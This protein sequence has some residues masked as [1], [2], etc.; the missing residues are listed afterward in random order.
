M[1]ERRDGY[2]QEGRKMQLGGPVLSPAG[3]S[4]VTGRRMLRSLPCGIPQRFVENW[5]NIRGWLLPSSDR[6]QRLRPSPF[7]SVAWVPL[8]SLQRSAEAQQ[9]VLQALTAQC[10]AMS[11]RRKGAMATATLDFESFLPDQNWN[12]ACF[13]NVQCH[14][15]VGKD[16]L[17][18]SMGPSCYNRLMKCCG[19]SSVASQAEVSSRH[20]GVWE[21]GEPRLQESQS[22]EAPEGAGARH[23]ASSG[24]A[25]SCPRVTMVLRTWGRKPA[26]PGC[27]DTLLFLMAEGT[28]YHSR[29]D[30]STKGSCGNFSCS[31]SIL[32]GA[33][34]PNLVK[35]CVVGALNNQSRHGL[36][37]PSWTPTHHHGIPGKLKPLLM[38]GITPSAWGK[39]MPSTAF[40]E[41]DEGPLIPVE[42]RSRIPQHSLGLWLLSV[43]S[44][45]QHMGIMHPAALSKEATGQG[46]QSSPIMDDKALAME[47]SK[48]ISLG[49]HSP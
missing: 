34:Q 12:C 24:E 18:A 42:G 11:R 6:H 26:Q 45:V 3:K 30:F 47:C 36:S 37:A 43:Y 41:Y 13:S 49:H 7:G 33:A 44:G 39:A 35:E 19:K 21:C 2:S 16:S 15:R 20:G 25:A 23:S 22:A 48:L 10:R 32:S 38:G 28:S 46:R 8:S 27:A 31:S 4:I 5:G 17:K 40:W 1:I 9:L 29:S 14:N